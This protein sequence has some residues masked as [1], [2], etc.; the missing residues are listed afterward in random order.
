MLDFTL[1][2]EQ[3]I[4]PTVMAHS[5]RGYLSSCAVYLCCHDEGTIDQSDGTPLV[6]LGVAHSR[7]GVGTCMH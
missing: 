2:A 4:F 6:C 1:I 5:S 3:L 7:K